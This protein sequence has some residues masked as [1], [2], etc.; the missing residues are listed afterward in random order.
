[1]QSAGSDAIL[2]LG[3]HRSGT[4]AVAGALSLLGATP[5]ATMLPAA[6]DNPSGFWEATS[7]L[8]VND[9]ILNENGASWYDCLEFDADGFGARTR[10]IA[11][12]LVMLCMK[13]EFGAAPL[14]LIK[15]PRLC[16]LLD[17]WLPALR[18]VGTSPIVVLVLRS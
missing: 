4:S 11:L 14:K 3:M 6:V 7:L 10:A 13:S 17:L 2:V 5:P 8:G 18:A 1:M 12:T 15:D 9:W 16:L